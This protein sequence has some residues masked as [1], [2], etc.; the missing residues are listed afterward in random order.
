MQVNSTF[1]VV[2]HQ[3]FFGIKEEKYQKYLDVT[4]LSFDGQTSL[5]QPKEKVQQELNQAGI[6]LN[7]A[8]PPRQVQKNQIQETQVQAYLETLKDTPRYQII[9]DFWERGVDKITCA[10]LDNALPLCSGFL[11]AQLKDKYEIGFVA[12]KSSKWIAEL[13]L[14]YLKHLPSGHFTLKTDTGGAQSSVGIEARQFLV[15]DDA[16]Y[17]G[18]QLTVVFRSLKA[19]MISQGK[20]GKLIFVV[21]FISKAAQE[22]LVQK[23]TEDLNAPVNSAAYSPHCPLKV[24]LITTDRPVKVMRD[25]F[26]KS[27]SIE[28]ITFTEWKIPDTTSLANAVR[29]AMVTLPS[30]EDYIYNFLTDHLPCYKQKSYLELFPRE[31]GSSSVRWGFLYTCPRLE[32]K[33]Q[34]QDVGDSED[35]RD[36][37]H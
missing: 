13:A 12:G 27:K 30:G 24:H 25:Y 16:S 23:L 14:P 29:S 26:S 10:E 20:R 5:P 36:N 34:G 1:P 22:Y 28:G 8:N 21:P 3:E 15:F 17:S 6:P 7:C 31:S 35:H 37:R 19:Q 2:T 9:K 33:R 4:H 11:D 18:H 32:G